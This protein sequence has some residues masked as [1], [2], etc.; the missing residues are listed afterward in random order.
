MRGRLNIS[1]LLAPALFVAIGALTAASLLITQDL[2]RG[3]DIVNTVR[4]QPKRIQPETPS[5]TIAFNLTRADDDVDIE[6]V[7]RSDGL[8]RE[9]R[10]STSLEPGRHRLRWD[11]L[12]EQG[13]RV[14]PALYRIRISLNQQDRVITLPPGLRVPDAAEES[15]ASGK[16]AVK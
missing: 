16:E 10:G 13:V 4:I 11:L 8:V 14:R 12:D 3:T 2:R 1:R 5:A 6:V 9:L 15:V 7:D